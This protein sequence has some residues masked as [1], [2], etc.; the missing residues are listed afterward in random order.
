M[1]VHSAKMQM[2]AACTAQ[3]LR[4]ELRHVRWD[5]YPSHGAERRQMQV[6]VFVHLSSVAYSC[7]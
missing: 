7:L 4:G 3:P 2:G 6:V 1:C 5:A